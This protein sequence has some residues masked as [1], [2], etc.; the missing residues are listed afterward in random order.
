MLN[1]LVLV[2]C[3][4]TYLKRKINNI[5]DLILDIKDNCP[6]LHNLI[7]RNPQ[8]IEPCSQFIMR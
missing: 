7:V 3:E 5:S 1:S 4:F 2:V 6:S 8:I